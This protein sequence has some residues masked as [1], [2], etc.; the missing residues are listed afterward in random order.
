MG[1]EYDYIK[2]VSVI[3]AC[4]SIGALETGKYIHDLVRY[5]GLETNVSVTS[6]LID[7]YAKCGNINLA[8]DVFD[9]LRYRSVVSWTSIIGAC[10]SHGC[11]EDAVFLFSKMKAEGIK[12]NIYTFTAVL[13][14]CRHSGFVEEGS[15][16][17]A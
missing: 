5:K 3:S 6:A 8:R 4:A 11:G 12:P 17:K 7:M 9:R 16:S 10:A 2:L 15:I 1:V 13:T 14:A